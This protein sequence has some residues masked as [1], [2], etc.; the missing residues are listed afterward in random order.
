MVPNPYATQPAA[1][2]SAQAGGKPSFRVWFTIILLFLATVLNYLDRQ[3]IS[4]AAPVIRE[5]MNLSLEQVGLLFSAFFWV[6]AIFQTIAGIMIDRMNVKWAYAIAVAGWSL[7]GAAGGL[8]VGFISLFMLRGLLAVFESANWPAALRVVTRTIPPNQRT[9]ANGIFQSG[10]SIGALIAP[11]IMIFLIAQYSWRFGFVA[12]GLVGLLWVALWLWFFRH[13]KSVGHDPEQN[14]DE[15]LPA[16]ESP[17]TF[18]QI[19]SSPIFWSLVVASGFLNPVQ[20]FYTSWLPTYF[21]E[22]G[23]GFGA[24][25]AAKLVIAY[26]TYDLG[27]YLSGGFV[28]WL[29]R[30]MEVYYAR[31]VSV[32]VG[33]ACM[34]SI[35]GVLALDGLTAITAI[36]SVATFGLGLFMPNY[37][38]FASEVSLRR[39]STVSGFLGAAGALTGAFFM[40]LVGWLA[41]VGGFATPLVFVGVLPLISLLGIYNTV[42]LIAKQHGPPAPPIAEPAAGL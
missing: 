9:L 38:A 30:R 37:L 1:P 21:T 10:T 6:Y 22:S 26:L 14:P 11:P 18:K 24:G 19:F 35:V 27:L 39:V 17:Y 2:P 40:W 41:D 5:E 33:A 31:L 25:L 16:D 32:I 42:R 12:V 23:E 29:A 28:I 8:A 13:E 34:F 7:A 4:V 36:I 3:T 20:Y 15:P